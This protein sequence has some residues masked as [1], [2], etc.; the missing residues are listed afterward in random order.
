MIS[1]TA[2]QAPG[3]LGRYISSKRYATLLDI[4][5]PLIPLSALGIA[6]T[7][8]GTGTIAG[9]VMVN[10]GYI[11]TILTAWG[12]L[13]I[14]G[15]GWREIGMARP[16]SWPRTILIGI[17]AMAA[18]I[19]VSVAL[20]SIA[21]NLPGQE[22]APIDQSRFNPLAGNPLRLILMV[23]LAWTTIAF[24][25]EMFFRAYLIDR[26]SAL[27]GSTK[28]VTVLA[29]AISAALFGLVHFGDQGLLG[30]VSTA[31]IGLLWGWIFIRT[32]RNL[33]VTIIA[34]GLVNSLSFI[35]MF[36][37]VS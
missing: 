5:L 8:I 13:K 34:H 19:F 1:K 14:R 24:G 11:L 23:G 26:F 12:M 10:A 25:E 18:A 31:A 22:I 28:H 16:N 35:L 4:L 7:L 9:G 21:V 36:A 33:W 2:L 29:V 37:G 30:T 32:G 20:Q 27:L 3:D 6:G 17:A 15:S